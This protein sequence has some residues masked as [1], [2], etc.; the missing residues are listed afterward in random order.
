ML[1]PTDISS[2]KIGMN[3]P[4]LILG[5]R[6]TVGSA[7]AAAAGDRALKAAR[8][9][10]SGD[11]IAYDALIDDIEP[12]IGRLNP[13]PAAV[14]IAFGIS[15]THTCASDRVGSRR[16]NVDRVL[17]VATAAAKCGALPVLFS[18]DSVFD[19][20]PTYWSEQDMPRPTCEYGQQKAEVEQRIS[21]LG[22]TSLI[23]RLSRVIADHAHRRDLLYQWCRRVQNDSPIMVP[24]DQSFTPIAAGDVGR[25]AL[26]LIDSQATGLI[27]VA[28]PEQ[29]F[30]P[31]LFDILHRACDD[32]GIKQRMKIDYCRV[33]DLP[34]IE[35]RPANTLLSIK[36]LQQTMAPRFTPL[37]DS[38]KSVAAAAFAAES[39]PITS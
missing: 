18:T 39:A 6:G 37:A 38:V 22:I 3:A 25:I 23:I 9:P 1:R 2:E 34:G 32:L 33:A 31:V 35:Q 20:S 16:L 12:I 24:V 8:A 26:A 17:A 27:N 21:T 30:A 19:G 11:M 13:R 28:G 36:R 4:I 10:T 15:G 14:V 5:G 7:I 29:I